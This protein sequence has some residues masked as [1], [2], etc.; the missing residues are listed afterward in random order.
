MGSCLRKRQGEKETIMAEVLQTVAA[1]P[2][3][4]LKSV[5]NVIETGLSEEF[6]IHMTLFGRKIGVKVQVSL[7]SKEPAAKG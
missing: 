2:N 1:L 3:Q 4:V 6:D 7:L 5:D